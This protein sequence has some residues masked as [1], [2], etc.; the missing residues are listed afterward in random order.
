[1]IKDYAVFIQNFLY[2]L[3]DR[4]VEAMQYAEKHGLQLDKDLITRGL[5]IQLMCVILNCLTQVIVVSIVVLAT[6]KL[7]TT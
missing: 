3:V 7:C 4:I 1:M 6:F 2:P 5:R